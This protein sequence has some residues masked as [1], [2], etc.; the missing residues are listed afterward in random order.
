MEHSANISPAAAT[1]E[2]ADASA[3][4]EADTL[5]DAPALNLPAVRVSDRLA[6]NLIEESLSAGADSRPGRATRRDGWTPER[7]RIFL[8]ALAECG[9]V[10]DAARAAGMTKRSAYNLRNRAEGRAFH[11][12]WAAAEQLA[13]RRLTGELLSRALNGVVEVDVRDG[14][15]RVERHRF[16]NRLAMRVLDRLD[17]L[18]EQDDEETRSARFVA[19]EFDQFLDLVCAGGEGAAEFVAARHRADGY[20]RDEAKLLERAGNYERYG[21]GL[22]GEIDV[23][24]LDPGRMAEWTEEQAERAWRSGLL[25]QLAGE[26]EAAEEDD[27]DDDEVEGEEEAAGPGADD[28]LA[29]TLEGADPLTGRPSWVPDDFWETL[30][31]A[32]GD[33]AP[34]PRPVPAAVLPGLPGGPPLPR[35]A[36]G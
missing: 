28:V 19:Q 22:P 33:A 12:A 30:L 7:I 35:R 11:L 16:D 1:D 15:V 23:A 17:R 4:A 29:A 14:E 3:S 25:A 26:A 20:R 32:A 13:R 34:A 9:V 8:T 6:P 24:D 21:A 36:P 31:D 27:E 18:A 10:E 2:P 5:A